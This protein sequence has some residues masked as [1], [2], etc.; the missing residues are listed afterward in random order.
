MKTERQNE[1]LQKITELL[2]PETF[3]SNLIFTS[4]FIAYFENTADY[5]IDQPK[6]FFSD[7]FNSERGFIV[8]PEYKIEVLDLAPKKPINASLLWFKKLNGNF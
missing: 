6:N 2:K 4:I 1:S 3:K 5:I 7:C 8:S